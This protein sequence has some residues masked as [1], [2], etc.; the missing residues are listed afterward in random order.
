MS[1]SRICG[2]LNPGGNNKYVVTG[3]FHDIQFADA[4]V[5]V[6]F[7]NALDHAFDMQKLIAEIRRVLAPNGTL[8]LEIVNG[9]RE[10]YAPGYFEAS[11][12]ERID[13]VVGIFCAQRFRVVKR[14]AIS[15]P[16]QGQMVC[17]VREDAKPEP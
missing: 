2:N 16:W 13:D 11:I 1:L 14:L 15:Y 17:F 9:R 7:T 6:V 10:G 5:D 12:W 4:S 8:I 3:D